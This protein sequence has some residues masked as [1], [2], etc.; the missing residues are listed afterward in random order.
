MARRKACPHTYPL[1]QECELA[2]LCWAGHRGMHETVYPDLL[3]RDHQIFWDSNY[4]AI[5]A[6]VTEDMSMDFEARRARA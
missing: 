4:P 1:S 3:G 5:A 2:C 6:K